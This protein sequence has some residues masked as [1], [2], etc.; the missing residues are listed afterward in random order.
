MLIAYSV[1]AGVIFLLYI[2]VAIFG[3][4]QR[5]KVHTGDGGRLK[6]TSNPDEETNAAYA[7]DQRSHRGVE[8]GAGRERASYR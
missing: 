5:E 2:V 6:T 7:H 8:R 3:E 4:V 1:V